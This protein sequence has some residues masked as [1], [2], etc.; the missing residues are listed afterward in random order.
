MYTVFL[1][2]RVIEYPSITQSKQRA[3]GL[4]GLS[5]AQER[6]ALSAFEGVLATGQGS[7][8]AGDAAAKPVASSRAETRDQEASKPAKGVAG[9][10]AEVKAEKAPNT[11]PSERS[12][13]PAVPKVKQPSSAAGEDKNS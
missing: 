4:Q 2:R 11:L 12:K 13:P 6:R 9:I 8:R 1:R 3:E 10:K 7:R 5:S